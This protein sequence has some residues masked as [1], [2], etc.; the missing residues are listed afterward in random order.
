MID[1]VHELARSRVGGARL[2]RDRALADRG[3]KLVHRKQ[4]GCDIRTAEALEAGKRQQRC[5]DDAVVELAQPRLDIAPKRHDAEIRPQSF[6]QRLPSQR[7]GADHGPLRQLRDRRGLAADEDVAHVLARQAGDKRQSIGQPG[8]QI[9]GR[10][11][12][13]ID[14]VR[15]QRLLDLL[16]EQPLAAGLR[17]RAILDR[18]AGRADDVQGDPHLVE[19]VGG[20]EACAH[21][22]RLRERQRRAARADAQ[23]RRA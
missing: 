19:S 11:H 17:E 13:E 6:H 12:G 18:V 9:L 8:R 10:V 15:Q 2:D 1:G 16:G 5:V 4:R 22:V 21:L 23:Q 20:G 14:L 7:S 3:G